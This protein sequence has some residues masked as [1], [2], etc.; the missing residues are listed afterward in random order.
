MNKGIT[1]IADSV[2]KKG[3]YYEVTFDSG[4]GIVDGG[5]TY[6]LLVNSKEDI[7]IDKKNLPRQFVK[8]EI[9]TGLRKSLYSYV[10]QG[11]NTAIQVKEYSLANLRQAFEWI[12]EKLA[13][14]PYKDCVAF[15]ENDPAPMDVR[16]I[17]VL[18]D[19]FNVT[20]FPNDSADQPYRAYASKNRVLENYLS[21]PESYEKLSDVFDD[22]LTLYDTISYEAKDLYN[23]AGGRA[24]K[25]AFIDIGLRGTFRFHFIQKEGTHRVN[26]GALLPLLAAFR[27][28][29]ELKRGK[30]YWLYGF[31]FVLE[32]WRHACYDL[33]R[34]T[35]VTSD[36]VEHRVSAIGRNPMH[37]ANLHSLVTKKMMQLRKKQT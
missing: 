32:L 26:R 8:I 25:L 30:A 12:K 18:L 34:A 19:C 27:S 33:L 3:E 4:Q 11:L 16:D 9:I 2:R 22:I 5:H 7:S 36:Q 1:M 29:L 37:W 35:K 10:T 28:C 21:K 15:R 14:K 13:D 6:E 23:K 17:L 24:G 31:D 20:E